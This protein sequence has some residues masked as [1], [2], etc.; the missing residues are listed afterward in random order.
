LPKLW[1]KANL[2]ERRKLLLS[3]L[4]GVY[5]DA[6]KTKSIISIKPKPPFIP[7]FQ[8]AVWR[9]GSA[10]QVISANPPILRIGNVLC[11]WW[12]RGRV[13]LHL[14]HEGLWV[15]VVAPQRNYLLL[16]VWKFES[17]QLGP[18]LHNY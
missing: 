18:K 6:K 7:I 8:V 10:I 9:E 2:A 5:I 15:I 14:K 1:A 3:I 12:R 13:K 17:I 11:F 4:G 16:A